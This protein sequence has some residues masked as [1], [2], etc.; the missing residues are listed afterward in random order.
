MPAL[1]TREPELSSG[2]KGMANGHFSTPSDGIPAG[3]GCRCL[4]PLRR[5]LLRFFRAGG[6]EHLEG[7]LAES[8]V[9]AQDTTHLLDE[10]SGDG[11]T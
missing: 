2:A 6:Q 1:G 9:E 11:E 8:T 3:K 7:R 4:A 5:L 10:A